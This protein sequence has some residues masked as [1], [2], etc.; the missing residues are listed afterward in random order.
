MFATLLSDLSQKHFNLHQIA[1]NFILRKWCSTAKF[2]DS[3]KENC[4]NHKLYDATPLTKWFYDFVF[5]LGAWHDA[6][7]H[8]FLITF[9]SSLKRVQILWMFS[10]LAGV[11]LCRLKSLQAIEHKMNCTVFICIIEKLKVVWNDS[12]K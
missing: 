2:L 8:L 6:W 4:K 3:Q 5:L 1:Q 12:L 10:I 9:L 11:N 7:I